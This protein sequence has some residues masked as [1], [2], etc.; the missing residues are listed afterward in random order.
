MPFGLTEAPRKFTK[1]CKPPLAVIRQN[2]FTITAYLD[3]FFQCEKTYEKCKD[4]I[5]FVYNLLVTLGF[6]PNDNK[7]AYE[8]CQIIESLGHVINS[9]TMTVTL[10][11]SKTEAIISLCIQ[12]L[13]NPHFTI[14]HL[15]T[16]IGKLISCFVVHPLGRLHYRSMEHLKVTALKQNKGN[17]EAMVQLDLPSILDIDWWIQTLPTAAAPITRRPITS[18]FT[19]DASDHG[20]SAC[21]DG[22]KANSQFSLLEYPYS[23]NTKEI[24]PVLLGLRSHW[25][26]FPNQHILVMS[27]STT[28]IAVIQHM[29]S[30]DSL[31]HDRLARDIWDFTA[32]NGIWLSMTHIPGKLNTESDY[33]SR[34][35]NSNLEWTL[36]QSTFDS[37]IKHYRD[38]GPVITDLFASRLNFKV[39]P[40]VSFGPDPYCC[41]VDCFTM[42]W[43]SPYVFYAYPPFSILPKLL[44][45][46]QQDQCQVL[47]VF[48]FWQT[49]IWFTTLMDLLILDIVV[50]PNDPPIFLPRDSMIHHPLSSKVL[51]CTAMLSG[52]PLKREDFQKT[53]PTMSLTP[54]LKNTR[55]PLPQE[56]LS[57]NHFVWNGKSVSVTHL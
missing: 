14:R 17:F 39:T 48:P 27:D 40:Y 38:Y 55:K 24:F 34:H 41:H 13:R 45:K 28:A 11:S 9:I 23:T 3:D 29:G 26:H 56:W 44:Q 33:G 51:L 2:G 25:H 7:S 6:L 30:M 43:K 16:I 5:V 36:P 19:C 57:G 42:S 54:N 8:P 49:Q 32:S 15:C 47:V 35:F 1:L 22:S 37:M 10:P 20:W 46:I 31:V 18:V 21:F 53:W 50:I 52:D 4:S 12:A